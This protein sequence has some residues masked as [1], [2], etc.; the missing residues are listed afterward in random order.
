MFCSVVLTSRSQKTSLRNKAALHVPCCLILFVH[1]VHVLC[2][3][4]SPKDM[5]KA[6]KVRSATLSDGICAQAG[7]TL[8]AKRCIMSGKKATEQQN[9]QQQHCVSATQQGL[10]N[11]KSGDQEVISSEYVANLSEVS[12]LLVND[13]RQQE[14]GPFFGSMSTWV[15]FQNCNR[16]E[17]LNAQVMKVMDKRVF[18]RLTAWR[19][20]RSAV[21]RCLREISG[22]QHDF[23]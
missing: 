4:G 16:T 2:V 17:S 19:S 23:L 13:G 14:G 11:I 6:D 15:N 12:E 5:G 3:L 18:E 8:L 1:Q 20:H 10:D 9:G 21:S 7:S 22:Q